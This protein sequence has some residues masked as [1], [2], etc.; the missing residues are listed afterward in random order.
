MAARKPVTPNPAFPLASGDDLWTAIA[1]GDLDR[2][3]ALMDLGLSPLGRLPG[4][5]RNGT[6]E[7]TSLWMLACEAPTDRP[8]TSVWERLNESERVAALTVRNG[9]QRTALE[10]AVQNVNAPV[11]AQLVRFNASLPERHRQGWNG[12]AMLSKSLGKAAN[13]RPAAARDRHRDTA[14]VHVLR[15]NGLLPLP[16]GPTDRQNPGPMECLPDAIR[17][18]AVGCVDALLDF[19]MNL[20]RRVLLNNP[21]PWG[22]LLLTCPAPDQVLD[23]CLQH[24]IVPELPEAD[25]PQHWEEFC[26]SFVLPPFRIDNDWSKSAAHTPADLLRTDPRCRALLESRELRGVMAPDAPTF[27]RER[28]RL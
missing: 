28:A 26:R 17:A 13:E 11:V 5:F 3:I 24:G 1:H 8:V 20:D 19:P 15:D 4:R 18:G 10:T 2:L 21:M 6:P 9:G 27:A 14:L 12:W 7:T 25:V 23:V 22:W 16:S